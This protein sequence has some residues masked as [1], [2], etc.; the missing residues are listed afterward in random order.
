MPLFVGHQ[1]DLLHVT[2]ATSQDKRPYASRH[3][4]HTTSKAFFS[5]PKS[6]Q[7]A[8]RV[9]PSFLQRIQGWVLSS[10]PSFAPPPR[11]AAITSWLLPLTRNTAQTTRK[12]RASLL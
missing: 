9:N 12:R 2:P 4:R 10:A 7:W 1:T 5:I 11:I 8:T 6:S 3:F